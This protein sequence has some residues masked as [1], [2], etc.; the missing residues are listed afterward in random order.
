MTA[1][2]SRPSSSAAAPMPRRARAASI[3]AVSARSV[4]SALVVVV[5]PRRARRGAIDRARVVVFV[6]VVAITMANGARARARAR[7]CVPSRAPVRDP[8]ECVETVTSRS[9]TTSR[10]RTERRA[11]TS[12][13]RAPRAVRVREVRDGDGEDDSME[14]ST[15]RNE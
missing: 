3:S 7:V 15:L 2:S 8:R 5:V 14:D 13:T 9:W 1:S 12:W 4:R 11:R 10:A 6:V